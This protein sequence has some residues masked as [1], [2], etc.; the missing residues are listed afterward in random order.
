[1]ALQTTKEKLYP[2][3]VVTKIQTVRSRQNFLIWI[4]WNGPM[5]LISRSVQRKSEN[6]TQPIY[7]INNHFV[8]LYFVLFNGQHS[9]CSIHHRRCSNS[10]SCCWI[11]KWP[12]G[13]IRYLEQGTRWSCINNCRNSNDDCWWTL[14]TVSYDL[15]L[16]L[17]L[18]R[19]WLFLK[20]WNR[21][22]GP[23]QW[24]QQGH[25]SD[26]VMVLQWNWTLCCW[27]QLLQQLRF[28]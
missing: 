15:T 1:M 4:Q 16:L 19:F 27:F 7:H 24:W 23:G 6:I 17:R 14:W 3:D 28:S 18:W 25:Y 22:L 9:W 12:M 21:S 20:L 13:P 11:S 26:L 10:K 5:V 2:P 8:K